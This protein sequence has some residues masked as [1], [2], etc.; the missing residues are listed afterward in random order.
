[1]PRL[2]WK[3]FLALWLSIMAFAVVVSWINQVVIVRNAIEEPSKA[4]ENR[5]ERLNAKLS[6]DLQE[7]GVGKVKRTLMKLPRGLHNHIFVLDDRGK[8]LLG[9]DRVLNKQKQTGTKTTTTKLQD[10]KGKTLTLATRRR[11]RGERS[12]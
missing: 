4:F 11:A 10:A 3:L 6:R 7:G 8:E 9:R 12:S 5:L 2:F 1:M